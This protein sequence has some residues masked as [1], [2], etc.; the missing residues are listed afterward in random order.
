MYFLVCLR[1][2]YIQVAAKPSFLD[3]ESVPA[4]LLAQETAICKEQTEASSAGKKAEIIAKMVTGKLSKRLAEICLVDQVSQCEIRYYLH[5]LI[6]IFKCD[7]ITFISL[8]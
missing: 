5:W 2:T 1:P 3:K 7:I 6:I 4:D 8:F